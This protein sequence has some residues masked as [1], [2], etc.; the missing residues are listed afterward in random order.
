MAIIAFSKK[1]FEKD[2]GKIDEKMQNKI[3]LF[4]T[5]VENVT[6]DEIQ[7]EVFPNRPDMLSYQGFK[8]G[9]LAY[10][11]KKTGLK[12]YKLNSP[13]KDY[14]VK[15]DSSVSKIRPYTVCAVVKELKFDNEKIKEIIEI[16][17]KIH[18]TLGRKRKK[19]A[20]GIYPLE[21][22]KFP[23]TYKALKP[24]EIRFVPLESEK[25]MNGLEILKNHPTGKEYA[26]LLKGMEKFPVFIDAE[27]KI[28]SMPPIIN[29]A[30]TGRITEETRDVFI[31]CSGFELNI[32]KKCINII[33]TCLCDMG[34]KI[35]QMEI[36]YNGK[37]QITPDLKPEEMKISLEN[38]NKFLGVDLSEKEIKKLF[39]LMG[40]EYKSSSVKIPAWRTDIMHE[41][42][43]IEDVAIAYGYDKFVPEIPEISTIGE[44]SPR[45]K[46]KRKFS[47]ILT[48]LGFLEVCNYHLTNKENQ[49]GKMKTQEE[50]AIKVTDSKTEYNMLRKNLSHFIMKIFSENIDV[51]YPQK[52]FEI[53]RVFSEDEKS[54]PVESESLSIGISP[55]NFT[56]IR[57]VVENFFESLGIE[58]ELKE[59][60]KFPVWFI[61]GRVAEVHIGKKSLGFL[62]EIHPSILRNWKIKMP[63][64]LLEINLEEIFEVL[65]GK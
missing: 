1:Q 48:G 49:F 63:V 62:G 37:K 3:A 34:G 56:D 64:G 26:H 13:E 15:V 43:L 24:A 53:G 16:Q 44:E 25:E 59:T 46:I 57:Q 2:I 14:I 18:F 32:L 61:S 31:E 22:I 36:F 11:G 10:L 4:G 45:E 29:S 54:N 19:L 42:D 6:S 17:E 35:Y 12:N 38:T 60:E 50:G 65:E 21:K 23:I 39:E 55:G 20:I 28:L 7:I 33:S 8:R 41:V 27:N 9:F 51:E 5:P 52:I 47:E 30:E 40:H 58:I